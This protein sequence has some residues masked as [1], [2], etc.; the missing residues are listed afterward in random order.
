MSDAPELTGPFGRYEIR[1]LLGKGGMGRVYL[2]WDTSLER[3]VALKVPQFEVGDRAVLG[4]RFYREAR[5]AAT[6]R[7]PNICTVYDVGAVGDI[8][9]LT[10]AYIEGK[11]LHLAKGGWGFARIIEVIRKVALALDEAHQRGIIH[12]DL[13]PSNILIDHRGEPIVL[14]F[15]LA[16]SVHLQGEVRLT[17][18]NGCLGTPAYMSPEQARGEEIPTPGMDI[19]SLGI[20]LYELLTG[21]LPFEGNAI[22]MLHAISNQDAPSPSL[23]R[24]DLDPCLEQ[25][26]LCALA[27]D[28]Q[29]RFSTMLSFASALADPSTLSSPTVRVALPST[30]QTPRVDPNP[31]LIPKILELLRRWGWA[32]AIQ[33]IRQRSQ[34]APLEVNPHPQNQ[35]ENLPPKQDSSS[36]S[37]DYQVFLEWLLSERA[38]ASS[39]LNSLDERDILRGWVL[40][41]QASHALRERDYQAARESLD[42]AEALG[43]TGDMMLCATINH[44]RA[45]SL[46]HSGKC[47]A[48][49]AYL[50]RALD[51]FGRQHFMT[52]RV[53]D[54]LGMAYAYKGNFP[55]A[56][57]FYEQSIRHK[58]GFDDEAGI[59]ISYGQLGRLLLEWGYLDQAEQY[60]Q[61]DLQLAQKLRSRWSEA[62][63]YNHLGQV[64][65]AR[66]EEEIAAGKRALARRHLQTAAGWLEQSIRHCQDGRFPVSEGFAR[67][68]RA[69]VYLHENA[70]DA[71]RQE[72]RTAA[73]LFAAEEF[74]EGTAKVAFVEGILLRQEESWQPALNK[75]R[76]ALTHFEQT[77][78]KDDTIR[79]YWEIAR[80]QRDSGAVNP[81]VTRAYLEALSKAEA[82]RHDP[83]VR[84]IESEL[85]EVNAEAY[86]RHVYARVRGGDIEEDQLS[87]IEAH[88]EIGSILA[89]DLPGFA[90]YSQGLDP[91]AVLVT[92]NHLLSDLVDV[93]RQHG[94]RVL[95]YRGSGLLAFTQE[96]R[97]AERAIRAALHLVEALEEFNR[98]RRLLQLAIFQVRIGISSGDMLLGNVGTYH[99]LDFTVMGQTVNQAGVLRNEGEPGVPCISRTTY[100]LVRDRFSYRSETPR[101][102]QLAGFGPVEVWDVIIDNS[103]RSR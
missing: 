65:I 12:R 67:K 2:A 90:D 27:R 36:P 71:A 81:L 8:P 74:A 93:L 103:R 94:A 58:K 41:G 79:T 45:A 23:Y 92:F 6:L 18:P 28:S 17:D 39:F 16:R 1:R 13:K 99:K 32:K 86:L 47:D 15:G 14:D 73:Q 20:I 84:R 56:R 87:L 9:Y 101:M 59:A 97:H 98:P 54:T 80:T 10:M 70:L 91:E 40:C 72:I 48:A 38:S 78:E 30:A 60:F 25:I 26:C 3:E 49:L 85:H 7:H 83:L 24:R 95:A 64:A 100:D 19:F 75:F 89:I 69:M 4:E 22:S 55:V 11:P 44:T 82:S 57:E 5:S 62:Q 29:R 102:V 42:K 52:G 51:L 66:A 50:N 53:L 31:K 35:G 34:R 43:D 88:S 33:K 63:I 37:A 76:S 96:S 21:R 68:D 46:V 77:D 61:Q